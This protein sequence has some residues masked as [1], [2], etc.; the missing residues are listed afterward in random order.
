MGSIMTLETNIL[1]EIRYKT[2]TL[3]NPGSGV[4]VMNWNCTS[5]SQSYSHDVYVHNRNV[6]YL[7]DK[8]KKII[9]NNRKIPESLFS[10]GYTRILLSLAHVNKLHFYFFLSLLRV[11]VYRN[12]EH[13]KSSFVNTITTLL[14]NA[15]S[16][17]VRP[18]PMRHAHLQMVSKYA[19]HV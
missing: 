10:G 9:Q 15:Q 16:V 3:R 7:L 11:L 4:S 8:F 13:S 6:L 17:Y 1:N 5:Y 18:I 14:P 2:T 12:I 19:S